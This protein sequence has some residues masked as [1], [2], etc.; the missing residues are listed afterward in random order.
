MHETRDHQENT[1]AASPSCRFTA[2]QAAGQVENQTENLLKARDETLS[3]HA[4]K[5]PGVALDFTGL[6]AELAPFPPYR[7]GCATE[8]RAPEEAEVD[9]PS[10][11]SLRSADGRM[12]SRVELLT[13]V[14]L[15]G[16]AISIIPSIS[17]ATSAAL[18]R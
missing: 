7:E 18:L 9:K 17:W 4:Q 6:L 3:L 1:G 14:A 15:P 2:F 11:A 5:I 8:L 10:F 16:L 12:S 13:C